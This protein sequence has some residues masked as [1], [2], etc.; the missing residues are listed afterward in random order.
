M[1]NLK[2]THLINPHPPPRPA[3]VN[4]TS[5]RELYLAFEE[6]FLGNSGCIQSACGHTIFVFD[7]H[8]FHMAAITVEGVGRL[9]MRDEKPKILGLDTGFGLY[10]VGEP[11]ARHLR[12]AHLT[13]CEPDEVWVENPKSRAKWVYV[14][15]FDSKPY[16]FSV[17]LVTERPEE[18]SIIVPVSS[19]ACKNGDIGKWR[20]GER[21]HP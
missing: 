8:F 10:E 4:C 21:I 5:M 6:I 14:K 3:N 1:N 12:S 16:P 13:I 18:N 2:T 7:H 17:A 9:F 19:F 11:R 20:R 15:E